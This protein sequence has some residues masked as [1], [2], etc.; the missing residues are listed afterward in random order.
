MV[1]NRDSCADIYHDGVDDDDRHGR[2]EVL[3]HQLFHRAPS[4]KKMCVSNRSLRLLQSNKRLKKSLASVESDYV[5]PSGR[6]RY[7]AKICPRAR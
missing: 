2:D 3:S 1:C 6:I 4:V 7:N 5:N